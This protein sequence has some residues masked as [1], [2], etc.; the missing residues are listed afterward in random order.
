MTEGART[1]KTIG[2]FEILGRLGQGGMGAVYKARHPRTE[3]EVAIKVI[4]KALAGREEV[5]ERFRREI[6]AMARVEHPNVVRILDSGEEDGNAWY[7]MQLVDGIDL[8]TLYE[9]KGAQ[10]PALVQQIAAGLLSA[11]EALHGA[12]ILHRDLKPHNVMLDR[13]GRPI[14]MDLGLTKLADTE[15]MT[16]TGAL[17]G[18]PRYMPPELLEGRRPDERSDL[19]QVGLILWEVAAGSIAVK[20]SDFHEVSAR[21]LTGQVARI[22]DQV[23]GFPRLLAQVIHR[24]IAPDAAARF[25]SASEALAALAGEIPVDAPAAPPPI[26]APAVAG[27]GPAPGADA[28]LAPTPVP[29][30]GTGTQAFP[31]MGK[32]TAPE[33]VVSAST[34]AARAGLAVAGILGLAAGWALSGR[35]TPPPPEAIEIVAGVRRVAAVWRGGAGNRVRL[36]AEDAS[37]R[38]SSFP[39]FGPAEVQ[40]D[41]EGRARLV[42]DGLDG[43]R[44]YTAWLE[45][46][47]G[48]SLARTVRTLE[49]FVR[50][51]FP[52]LVGR[53]GGLALE[54]RLASPAAVSLSFSR[55]G[56][57]AATASSPQGLDHLLPLDDLDLS[58]ED[59]RIQIALEED[60]V[61]QDPAPDPIPLAR[62]L[63]REATEL[64]SRI[65]E[66]EVRKIVGDLERLYRVDKERTGEKTR[67]LLGTLPVVPAL[68]RFATLAGP[69]FAAAA[70][71]P[72]ARREAVNAL[73]A[74][75][76]IERCSAQAGV[77]LLPSPGSLLGGAYG[78]DE[79]DGGRWETVPL[80]TEE[81]ILVGLKDLWIEKLPINRIQ[82]IALAMPKAPEPPPRRARLAFD[83]GG[84]PRLKRSTYLK[85]AFPGGLTMA[86]L[87]PAR[88][89]ETTEWYRRGF[90]PRDLVPDAGPIK[91]TLHD[92]FDNVVGGE[93]S[94]RRIELEWLR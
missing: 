23:P 54:V 48:R 56:G 50:D 44:E 5:K 26:P 4:L 94:V 41:G 61:T 2:G 37:G 60:G 62:L 87:T 10:K 63:A 38:A 71:P 34:L 81:K 88:G 73:E 20:G 53:P 58:R 22:E 84:R 16:K 55:K 64:A 83:L 59:G 93:I 66:P 14:V 65:G 13:S 57:G 1:L 19:Y 68:A 76:R 89:E 72:A 51:G 8:A 25:Q 36:V 78:P 33:G 30:G 77:E 21:I 40:P 9:K 27:P 85:V 92:I 90:D 12:G 15:T 75:R 24:L 82:E 11:M 70:L 49:G 47:G 67:E 80:F 45:Y 42:L 31:T 86:L 3:T 43:N 35:G 18:S 52:R 79:A 69:F 6:R 28:R 46:E 17:I 29:T 7:A 74:L 32:T 39:S 91:V